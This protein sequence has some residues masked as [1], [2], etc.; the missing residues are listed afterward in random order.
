MIDSKDTDRRN[1]RVAHDITD[2][3]EGESVIMTLQ[4]EQIIDGHS[5]NDYQ[6][7]LHNNK[8]T[9]DYAHK[10]HKKV[11]E[12]LG[13]RIDLD[14]ES[15][16]IIK[17][18]ILPQ[19]DEHTPMKQGF[20]LDT[21]SLRIKNDKKIL[22]SIQDKLGLKKN[23]VFDLNVQKKVASDFV[24]ADYSQKSFKKRRK[25]ARKKNKKKKKEDFSFLKQLED[26]LGED[27]KKSTHLGKRDFN[28]KKSE[29][30]KSEVQEKAEKKLKSYSDAV[31]RAN[32]MTAQNTNFRDRVHDEEP[33]EDDHEQLSI[34]LRNAKKMAEKRAKRAEEQLKELMDKNEKAAHKDKKEVEE[35]GEVLEFNE[36]DNKFDQIKKEI[37][38][39]KKLEQGKAPKMNT[40]TLK[41]QRDG[42]ASVIDVMLP[43]ERLRYKAHDSKEDYG[44]LQFP[45][46]KSAT[47]DEKKEEKKG[48]EEMREGGTKT[49][50]KEGEKK[51][52][53]ENDKNDDG[54]DE[55]EMMQEG[56]LWDMKS[57]TAA[58]LKMFR[59]RGM[60]NAGTN[61]NYA[62][63][64]KDV[65][66][67]REMERV[68]GDNDRIKLEY[69]DKKTGRPMSQKEAFK[70]MCRT[71]HNI[72][73]SK[74][75]QAKEEKRRNAM[76]NARFRNPLDMG[77]Y[78]LME[79]VKKATNMHYVDI[80]KQTKK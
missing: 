12:T 4:D 54:E 46:A 5:Y 68:G 60:L 73:P 9:E 24:D 10:F 35:G 74:I 79:E 80:T 62:A 67:H 71:F 44:G 72:F 59:N 2:L 29:M 52:E 3:N 32:K 48:K 38:E 21:N 55:L 14:P 26:E 66:F 40:L 49:E 61:V 19:Y 57:S 22:G 63:R 31:D 76:M 36:E 28:K 42:R 15:D 27:L 45:P 47:E 13:Q 37:Q 17:D 75:K 20:E 56:N 51:N 58:V 43:S 25:K 33:D 7:T 16:A 77:S 18:K 41:D 1:V 50:E 53:N 6:D 78:R 65:P 30:L 11:Q 23:N 39:I 8:M 70:D 34:M 64:S 69:R